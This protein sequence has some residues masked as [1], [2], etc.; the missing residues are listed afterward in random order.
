MNEGS[1][2]RIVWRN[3]DVVRVLSLV[4]L[5]MFIWRFFWTVYTA[6]LLVLL[7]VLIAIMIHEPAKLLSRWMPFR[8]AF[9]LVVILFLAGIA[10]LF[11]AVVPQI[12]E[13]V[14]QITQQL[15][16]AVA[17]LTEWMEQ[18]LSSGTEQGS[19]LPQRVNAQLAE[20]VG[21]F[22]PF[23]F[24]LIAM[25][26]GFF[27][28]IVLAIF[29]AAE[30]RLYRDLLLAL[31]SPGSREK[32]ERIYDEAGRS[33]RLWVI[34]KGFTM[35]GVGIFT[36]VGLVL[37]EIPGAL[38]FAALAAVLEFIPNFGPTIA[39]APAVITAFLISPRTA[40]YV[41][42]FYIVLQQIQSALTVPLVERRAVNIPSAALLA[43][44]LMLALGFGFLTLFV[45]TPLLAVIVVA[46]RI[47]YYEPTQELYAHDRREEGLA[48]EPH[49]VPAL[50]EPPAG[51]TSA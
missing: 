25:L 30:P 34:G 11:V 45:A 33:L 6:I 36:Y 2:R 41:T 9:T 7:A 3:A 42:I 19:D 38:A 21:R 51:P 5:F 23:A 16:A 48:A 31:V 12:V 35:L 44:Q 22:V 50:A 49:P 46:V 39:A 43:W 17:A 32:F 14:G 4:I 10:G 26:F 27:A 8:L 13:Q 1:V 37:F 20:F 29:L 24:N 28:V 18:N 40:L 47:L 15:P